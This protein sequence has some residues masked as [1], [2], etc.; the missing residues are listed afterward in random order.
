[1]EF[2]PLDLSLAYSKGLRHLLYA[3]AMRQRPPPFGDSLDRGHVRKTCRDIVREGAIPA[4]LVP[5]FPPIEEGASDI[6]RVNLK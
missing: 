6:D 4:S 5:L 3:L 2:H 1:M